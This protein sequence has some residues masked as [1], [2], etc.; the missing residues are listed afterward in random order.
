M[1]TLVLVALAGIL[2]FAAQAADVTGKW[3][4]QVP[5]RGGPGGRGPVEMTFVLKVEGKALTGSV[6]GG[7]G[8]DAAIRDGVINGDEISFTSAGPFGDAFYKGKV[9]GD[10][11]AFS[12]TMEGEDYGTKPTTFTATRAK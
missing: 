3:T 4:A 12:R 8:G 11:I 10:T 1:R 9:S 2:V 6:M 7:R 5:A